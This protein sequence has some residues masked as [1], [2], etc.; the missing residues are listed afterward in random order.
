MVIVTGSSPPIPLRLHQRPR[1]PQAASPF[2]PSLVRYVPL[3]PVLSS[4]AT[5]VGRPLAS[6]YTSAF[7]GRN[8][9]RA[10][11]AKTEHAVF[12]VGKGNLFIQRPKRRD[13]VHAAKI[14][15]ATEDKVRVFVEQNSFV[16]ADPIGFNVELALLRAT[17]CRNDGVL[18]NR[19]HLWSIFGFDGIGIIPEVESVHV[20]VVE[21]QAGVM[22]MIDAFT[23]ELLQR[24]AASDDG[25]F[26]SAQG[27]EDRFL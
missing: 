16:E 1:V 8:S 27:V 9:Q 12:F 19:T 17:L 15:P 6:G 22:R 24:I 10:D 13:A 18:K 4:L 5:V 23:G 11:N 14:R 21:P 20:F 7:M 3:T 2:F 25:A 26:G